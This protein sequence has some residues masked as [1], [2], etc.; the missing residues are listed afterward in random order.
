MKSRRGIE[1]LTTMALLAG[2]AVSYARMAAS[3]QAFTAISEELEFASEAA[4][5]IE[6]LRAKPDQATLETHSERALA[7]AV[8]RCA[9]QAQIEQEQIARIEP[10][11]PRRLGD[12]PYME[13]ATVVQLESVALNQL[14]ALAATLRNLDASMGQL[15]LTTLRI[16]APYQHET[17]SDKLKAE[18]WNVEFTLT[19]FVYSPKSPTSRPS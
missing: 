5:Q 9:S 6:H 10:Q 7:R 14:A 18:T 15:H 16:D 2:L 12:T 17:I 4:Q 3:R 11:P 1:I 8:E 19:Y 13:H